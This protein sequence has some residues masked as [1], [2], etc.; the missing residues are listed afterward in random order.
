M[1][2]YLLPIVKYKIERVP[3]DDSDLKHLGS[4]GT[5]RQSLETLDNAPTAGSKGMGWLFQSSRCTRV[6]VT[7][8]SPTPGSPSPAQFRGSKSTTALCSFS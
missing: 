8:A 3:L 1:Y 6:N 4:M 7:C 5:L 2:I